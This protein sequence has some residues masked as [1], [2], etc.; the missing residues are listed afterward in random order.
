M[1]LPAERSPADISHIG[2]SAHKRIRSAKSIEWQWQ[3]HGEVALLPCTMAVR[4]GSRVAGELS[5]AY[6]RDRHHRITPREC[7][8]MVCSMLV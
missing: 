3:R 6:C 8:D 1:D 5:F 2:P 7:S 4:G